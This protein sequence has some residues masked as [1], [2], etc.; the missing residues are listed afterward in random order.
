MSSIQLEHVSLSYPLLGAYTR[1]LKQSVLQALSRK[2]K[3][4]LRFEHEKVTFIDALQDISFELN[5]GDRLGLIG[6]NGAGKSTLLKV[7]AGI[8]LPSQG[9]MT[10]NGNISPLLGISVG[11]NPQATGYENIKFRCLLHGFNKQ[12]IEKVTHEVEEFTELGHFL[13]MPTKTYSSGMNVRLS[14]GIATAIIPD[15]LILDEVVGVGDIRFIEKAQAR[16]NRLIE[17]SNILVL[18]SHSNEIIY[19]FCNKILWLDQGRMVKLVEQP[20]QD[21]LIEYQQTCVAS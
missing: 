17:S 13:A 1:S 11:M 19:K 5:S 4:T 18:A 9:T 8:Y 6:P 3:T 12:Q 15:I 14:F 7:L 21:V 20:I 16:L 2:S 10:V